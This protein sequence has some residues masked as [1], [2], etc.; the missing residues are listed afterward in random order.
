MSNVKPIS[1]VIQFCTSICM[2]TYNGMPFLPEQINSIINQMGSNDELIIVDD[3]SEDGTLSFLENINDSRVKVYR[4]AVNIG[5]VQTFARAISIARGSYI[6]MADQD[7]IWLDGRLFVIKSALISGVKL[8]TTNSKFINSEGHIVSPLHPNLS[9]KDSNRYFRNILRIFAGRAY[10]DGCAMGF[11]EDFRKIILPIPSYVES[12][13][14]WIAMAANV[15]RS[16][17]HLA[18]YSLLRRIHTKNAS[19]LSR[20]FLHKLKSR[21]IFLLSLL[22]ISLRLILHRKI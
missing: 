10:Y 22:H 15:I 4:N 8:V 13:D 18:F 14:L 9:E 19:I 16:N 21:Y 2:A 3:V 12:H 6:L 17:R 5:H 20:P 11:R 1:S 7:D